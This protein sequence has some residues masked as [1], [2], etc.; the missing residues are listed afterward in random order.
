MNILVTNKHSMELTNL[1]IDTIQ[2][3]NGE[4]SIDDLVNQFSNFVF[5]KIK[6]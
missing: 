5:N 1:N 2:A 3:I 6:M 4:F